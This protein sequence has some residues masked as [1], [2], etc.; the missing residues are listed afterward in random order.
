MSVPARDELS[1]D[2]RENPPMPNPL[3][4]GIGTA[5]RDVKNAYRAVTGG[6]YLNSTPHPAIHEPAVGRAVAGDTLR[7]AIYDAADHEYDADRF[8]GDVE[9]A[10]DE[11]GV[12]GEAAWYDIDSDITREAA[13]DALEAYINDVQ[14]AIRE[15]YTA[16]ADLRLVIGDHPS[17][18][19][20]GL[21]VG[22]DI[23]G[24]PG[25][26]FV[27]DRAD[28]EGWREA[29][30]REAAIHETGHLLGMGH[31]I[32]DVMSRLTAGKTL[33]RH[34]STFFGPESRRKYRVLEQSR[35]QGVTTG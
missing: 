1:G 31:T 14:T 9:A 21:A 34:T 24:E 23:P 3:L 32:G 27:R 22:G 30:I 25:W 26:A 17:M 11:L 10:L 12:A 18:L 6:H 28:Q 15:R 2:P 35:G 5:L 13:D 29:Y 33:N 8:I 4:T 19:S 20:M 16:D 7:V